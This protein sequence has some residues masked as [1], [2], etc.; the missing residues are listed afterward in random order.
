[1]VRISS[2]FLNRDMIIS[3]S[4]LSRSSFDP[5]LASMLQGEDFWALLAQCDS[6][7]DPIVNL[8]SVFEADSTECSKLIR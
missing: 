4:S 3:L 6:I 2:V 8:I 1:M 7:L 5:E